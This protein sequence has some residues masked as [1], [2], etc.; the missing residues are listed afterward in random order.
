MFASSADARQTPSHQPRAFRHTRHRQEGQP[1]PTLQPDV[2]IYP[3]LLQKF[4]SNTPHL[5]QDFCSVAL[6]NRLHLT[7]SILTAVEM[8]DLA[9]ISPITSV[10]PHKQPQRPGRSVSRF[11]ITPTCCA[12]TLRIVQHQHS[13]LPL[14]NVREG[15]FS[16]D[17]LSPEGAWSFYQGRGTVVGGGLF[18]AWYNCSSFFA[19]KRALC[20][21]I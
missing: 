11:S 8:K 6:S 14:K 10:L 20:S 5:W 7:L 4:R 1:R 9:P 12:C 13:R 16:L 15:C 18:G 21:V 3:P 17:L 2:S 19:V